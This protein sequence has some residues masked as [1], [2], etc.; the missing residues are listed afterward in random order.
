M[1]VLLEIPAEISAKELLEELN[2]LGEELAIDITLK[3]S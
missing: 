2:R 1:K 3:K